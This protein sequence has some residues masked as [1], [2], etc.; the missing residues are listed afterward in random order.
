MDQLRSRRLQGQK[1]CQMFSGDD[2]AAADLQVAEL[3]G[4]HLVVEQVAGQPGTV[5]G[6]ALCQA[7]ADV[8]DELADRLRAEYNAMEGEN[9]QRRTCRDPFDLGYLWD[10]YDKHTSRERLCRRSRRC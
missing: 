7:C 2:P 8:L 10:D 4:A 1:R 9:Q 6:E 5:S 3:P